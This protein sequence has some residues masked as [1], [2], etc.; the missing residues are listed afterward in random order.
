VAEVYVATAGAVALLMLSVWVVSVLKQDVSIVDIVWGL[1]FVLIAGLSFALG[2]GYGARRALITLLT[3]VWGVR[4]S[5]YLLWR[6]WG[7]EED[8]RYRAMRRRHGDRF[9]WVSLYTVF[10]LQGVLMWLVSLP[11]QW[12]QTAAEPT[13]LTALD[14]AGAIVWAVGLACEAL[15]DWQLARFKRD[16]A[17]RGRVMDRGLWRY[18]RHPNYF[19][20]AVV[21]WGLFLIAA[22]T[23]AGWLTVIGPLVMTGLLRRVSGVPMLERALVKNR[24]DYAEYVRRTS[25]FVPWVPKA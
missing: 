1:G 21:W 24:P 25:P 10:A 2:D 4:L 18:T 9:R 19:G 11:V 6:N 17:N 3:T 8:F 20:D 12:A 13:R 22:A 15:G 23:P 16:P 14:A 7:R 5:L